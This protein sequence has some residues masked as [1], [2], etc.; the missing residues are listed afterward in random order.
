MT[1]AT[2]RNP[3]Q[4]G[5]PKPGETEFVNISCQ[6]WPF[7][8]PFN[9]ASTPLKITVGRGAVDNAGMNTRFH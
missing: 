4:P 3:G 8:N 7:I 6:Q 2:I 5:V 9:I 1:A